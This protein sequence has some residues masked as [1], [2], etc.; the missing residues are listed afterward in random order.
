MAGNAV[1]C[2][3]TISVRSIVR[4]SHSVSTVLYSSELSGL[5]YFMH[6]ADDNPVVADSARHGVR[7]GREEGGGQQDTAK[8]RGTH[9]RQANKKIWDCYLK[10][11]DQVQTGKAGRYG[12]R[13]SPELRST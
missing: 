12:A 8:S 3:T 2:C 5:K 6:S 4:C 10:A 9:S 13:H 1:R 11:D 7:R